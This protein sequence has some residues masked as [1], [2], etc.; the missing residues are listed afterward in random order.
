MGELHF[1]DVKALEELN[2]RNAES[3]AKVID[4]QDSHNRENR[5]RVHKELQEK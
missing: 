5:E 1:N 2:I 3:L 4:L